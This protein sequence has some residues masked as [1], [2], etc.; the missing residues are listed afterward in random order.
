MK[1]SS[2]PPILGAAGEVTLEI[3]PKDCVVLPE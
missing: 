2:S 3:D 1:I